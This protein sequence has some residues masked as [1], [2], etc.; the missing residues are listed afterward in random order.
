MIAIYRMKP[1]S[2]AHSS[3][4]HITPFLSK[5][6][7]TYTPLENRCFSRSVKVYFQG[8][9][10]TFALRRGYRLRWRCEVCWQ[11]LPL[12]RQILCLFFLKLWTTL[13]SAWLSFLTLATPPCR[14][15]W[16]CDSVASLTYWSSPLR[17]LL[18]IIFDQRST[19]CW[20]PKQP[21][22]YRWT[23][24]YLLTR[25]FANIAAFPKLGNAK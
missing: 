14:R 22:M 2:F 15:N 3:C 6:T 9:P 16:N 10:A 1:I 13:P 24:K 4:V 23:L 18:Y 8:T 21:K 25:K 5:Y 12:G 11:L 7:E 17:W 20:K 19:Y